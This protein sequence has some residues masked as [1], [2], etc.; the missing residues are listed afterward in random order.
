MAWNT[1][2]VNVVQ[3]NCAIRTTNVF[4]TSM[5]FR[6]KLHR[7][8]HITNF[9]MEETI[10]STD[11]TYSTQ[12][13]MVLRLVIIV[14]E[15]TNQACVFPES[16]ATLLTIGLDLLS[17]FTFCTNKLLQLFSVKCMRLSVI[18]TK[19]TTVDFPTAWTLK[20]RKNVKKPNEIIKK[21]TKVHARKEIKIKKNWIYCF[22]G[23]SQC[24]QKIVNLTKHKQGKRKSEISLRIIF[25]S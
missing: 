15:I 21:L 4:N 20:S 10:L 3:A 11:S 24:I 18:V 17:R 19:S 6:L 12:V 14:K 23:I 25:I 2:V 5:T 7:Q 16:D 1:T 13:T 8:A 22:L 9:T